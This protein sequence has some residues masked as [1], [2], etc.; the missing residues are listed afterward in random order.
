[1]GKIIID[2][3]A[4][5]F[6]PEGWSIRPE[7]QIPGAVDGQLVYDPLKISLYIDKAQKCVKRIPAYNLVDKLVGKPLLKANVLD[8]LLACTSLVPG[9]WMVDDYGIGRWIVFWGTVYRDPGGYRCV[10]MLWRSDGRWGWG[11]IALGYRLSD[12]CPAAILVG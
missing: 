12:L 3:D 7:D 8:Y 10:R 6:V 11:C 4:T 9:A 5:P 2:C 1:M